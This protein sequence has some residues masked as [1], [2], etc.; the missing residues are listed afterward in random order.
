MICPYIKRLHFAVNFKGLHLS[1]SRHYR[2]IPH[3]YLSTVLITRS[4]LTQMQTLGEVIYILKTAKNEIVEFTENS[5]SNKY[6]METR[7]S[8]DFIRYIVCRYTTSKEWGMAISRH[9]DGQRRCVN[10]SNS[11]PQGCA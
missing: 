3:T 4:H 6:N 10:K 7:P 8:D 1:K 9:P 5:N 11:M 2:L